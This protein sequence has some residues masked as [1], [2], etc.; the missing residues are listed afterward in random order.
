MPVLFQETALRDSQRSDC[1]PRTATS[2]CHGFGDRQ[3]AGSK[4][5]NHCAF[6]TC[7]WE[8][9]T[10]EK[11]KPVLW[12]DDGDRLDRVIGFGQTQ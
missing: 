7:V 3:G 10:S 8:V 11:L 1:P 9:L 2:G 6:F 5:T 12:V 4:Q